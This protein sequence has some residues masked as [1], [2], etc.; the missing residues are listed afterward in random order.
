MTRTLLDYIRL[1]WFAHM[2]NP[3]NIPMILLM[4]YTRFAETRATCGKPLIYTIVI[5]HWGKKNQPVHSNFG[6]FYFWK[7]DIKFG[8]KSIELAKWN[9]IINQ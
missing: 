5:I 9:F 4:G 1:D 6:I 2:H 7:F 3:T 8:F